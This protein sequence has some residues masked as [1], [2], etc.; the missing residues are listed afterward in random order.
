M[1]RAG[2]PDPAPGILD[3]YRQ[4]VDS[5]VD[6]AIFMLDTEGLVRTW[7]VGAER[8]TGYAASEIVGRPLS[9][10]YPL[11]LIETAE[12]DLLE[13]E[14]AGRHEAH[15]WRMRK[16]GGSFWA[17]TVITPLVA[18]GRHSGYAVVI[19]DLT[20]RR[21][22]DEERGE[23][24]LRL[25]LLVDSVDDYAIFLLDPRGNVATWNIGAQRIKGYRADEIIG[26][27]FSTFYPAE[28]V[29][30]GKCE[31]ELEVAST[32]GKFEEEGWR[33][34]KD[35][36]MFWASVVLTAVRDETGRLTG[37]GKVTRDLTERRASEEALRG[38]ERELRELIE[39]IRDYA[40]FRLDPGGHVASW[41]PGAER[42]KGYTA[43]EII[44]RHFSVFY[45]PEDTETGKWQ[46]ELADAARIGRFEDEGWRVRKDGS[47]FWANVI[48]SAVRNESGALV[49][50]SK[51]TRDLTERKRMEAE[52]TARMAAEQ[53]SR[54]K[55]EF[56]AI[57]GHELR[58]PLAPIVTALQLLRERYGEQSAHELRV[59]DRQIKHMVRLVEDLLDVS[60]ISQGKIRMAHAP[61]DVSEL[62]HR[63]IEVVSPLLEQ[64]M[65]QLELIAP[66][67]AHVMG[68]EQ[69]LVQAFANLL[70]NA[71]K[72]TA[73]RGQIRVELR[74]G[75]DEVIVEVVDNGMGMSPELVARAFDLFVQ[76]SQTSERARGGLGIGLSLVRS[77]VSMHGGQI[78]A[79][80]AGEGLGSTF[81]VRL[82]RQAISAAA[83]APAPTP[84]P[85]E[86]VARRRR[87]LFVDDNE[88][89]LELGALTLQRAGHEVITAIDGPQAL[90]KVATSAPELAILDLGLPV[91]DG[92][93]LA[94]ILREK[95]GPSLKL[96]ALSGY[97]QP[98]DRERTQAAGFDR[99]LVK[100][101]EGTEVLAVIDELLGT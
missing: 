60:R 16:D 84:R 85:A 34:R 18:A 14:R 96:V 73:P 88:D 62:L 93:E 4:L 76:G 26:R 53:A 43:E 22:A 48:V 33:V 39:S 52:Q 35:G 94:R 7:N 9:T 2:L 11:S 90:E 69:R 86:R 79:E 56:L 83:A 36:T 87:I 81:R 15:A 80:S 55:D 23:T 61:T 98:N 24:E 92:F 3:P 57:L 66:A 101:T 64:R 44:G 31:R 12:R 54:T 99:H 42:I 40:I 74:L 38:K 51:V 8:T 6:Y 41:N 65:H 77:I 32:V 27:H 91:M 47:R 71:A 46:R 50:F 37:F 28:D 1:S 21:R 20:A 19:H 97:G 29:A 70:T 75:V 49:G 25:R 13:V 82:P 78:E 17:S 95:F 5:V 30:A 68:D 10:F 89:A 45:A 100:P 72:Y 58:N 67:H 63:A 59:I